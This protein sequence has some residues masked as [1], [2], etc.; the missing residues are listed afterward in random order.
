ML[1][2]L[3]VYL[4]WPMMM[5]ESH[6]VNI[7]LRQLLP[8]QKLWKTMEAATAVAS[9][10]AMALQEESCS[11]IQLSFISIKAFLSFEAEPSVGHSVNPCIQTIAT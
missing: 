4:Y 9:M 7:S 2:I 8:R 3:G 1:L 5:T 11:Q 10:D 6:S